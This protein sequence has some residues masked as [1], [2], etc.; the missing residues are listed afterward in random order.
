[1]KKII[2]Y[3]KDGDI[4]MG[5]KRIVYHSVECDKCKIT[6]DDYKEELPK[7]RPNRIMVKKIADEF[8]F[9]KT[10]NNM[11]LCPICAK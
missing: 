6:L 1:M 10:E 11:W 8:G 3:V 9:V 5:I 4:V 7:I 2:L